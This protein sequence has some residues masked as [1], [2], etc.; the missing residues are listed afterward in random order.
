MTDL[1]GDEPCSTQ[2]E[3]ANPERCEVEPE[4]RSDWS[5][6]AD[7]AD[8]V[9]RI[10]DTAL[11]NSLWPDMILRVFEVIEKTQADPVSKEDLLDIQRHFARALS[12]SEKMLALENSVELKDRLLDHL[13]I[14]MIFL[15]EQGELISQKDR[16]DKQAYVPNP[17][18]LPDRPEVQDMIS[19]S[20]QAEGPVIRA[21]PGGTMPAQILFSR[22]QM[23]SRSLPQG[24]AWVLVCVDKTAEQLA[25]HVGQNFALTPAKTRLLAGFLRHGN[26]RRAAEDCGT[27][28]ETGRTYLKDICQSMGVRGQ[29]ELLQYIL[30]SSPVIPNDSPANAETL[31]TRQVLQHDD[32]KTLEIFTLGA[33]SG[34]PLIMFD[35]LTGGALDILGY[36]E[37]YQPLLDRLG[38]R[39]IIPCR[40]GTFRSSFRVQHSA[41][42]YAEDVAM[43][44]E[45][46]GLSRF[47]LLGYSYGSVAVL[48]AAHHLRDRVDRITLAS[49]FYPNYV[50][51]NWKE[52]DFFYQ[53]ASIIGRRW[54]GLLRRVIPFL[55]NSILHNMDNFCDRAAARADCAHEEAILNA[56]MVRQR[57]RDMLEERISQGMDG[58]IQEY[59][60]IAQPLDV[61]LG[62]ITA[63]VQLFHG[64]CDRINPMGGAEALAQDLG[65]VRLHKLPDMGHAFIYAEWDWLL[66]AAMG[67]PFDIPAATRRGLLTSG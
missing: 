67:Q 50:A 65:Q 28:Y 25:D 52:M 37:R 3:T 6:D 63:P 24:V 7:R 12:L 34:Y 23:V 57:S 33:Q 47:S 62:Q 4:D 32:G 13:G 39:L 64:M 8:L 27:S 53:I 2:D 20:Q 60:L 16:S 51:P 66:K 38:A 11:D 61:D 56:P 44:S 58:L 41:S 26:L 36:P 42:D 30:F 29:S 31:K 14:S 1:S 49:V 48:G 45:R 40:P 15:G 19:A 54:P 43:I 21:E 10:Y 35:A 55:A 18:F 59:Q 5:K 22:R 46:L 9:H 17:K